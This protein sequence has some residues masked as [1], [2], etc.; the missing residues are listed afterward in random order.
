V[1]KN[2]SFEAIIV[3]IFSCFSFVACEKECKEH[4]YELI[5]SEEST[6]VEKGYDVYQCVNCKE[7]KKED[8]QLKVEHIFDTNA[9]CVDREC[10]VVGCNHTEEATTEHDYTKKYIC[11]ECGV[12]KPCSLE[13][14]GN[15][16]KEELLNQARLMA[17]SM[18]GNYEVVVLGKEE[19]LSN[20]ENYTFAPMMDKTKIVG[21]L[22]VKFDVIMDGE[23]IAFT[24]YYNFGLQFSEEQNEDIGVTYDGSEI[25]YLEVVDGNKTILFEYSIT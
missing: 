15:D 21:G 8:K 20:I 19:T 22:F 7:I 12:E 4:N 2:L 14:I 17:G 25:W 23:N 5:V 11:S 1:R 9:T 13:I 6:C 18:T 16:Y 24:I 10:V 3:L